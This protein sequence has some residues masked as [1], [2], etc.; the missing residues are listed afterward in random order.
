MNYNQNKK[1][2]LQNQK[3][4]QL[5]KNQLNCYNTILTI[6]DNEFQIAHFFNK[7]SQIQKKILYQILCHDY[8][9]QNKIVLCVTFPNIAILLLFDKQISNFCFKFFLKITNETICNI[10]C[11]MRLYNFIHKIKL[12]I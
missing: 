10:I 4:T 5:N 12:I 8:K 6:V 1:L 7:I 9:S 3:Q 2:H 11:N